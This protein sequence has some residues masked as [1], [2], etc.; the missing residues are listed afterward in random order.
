MEEALLYKRVRDL[1]EKKL[2]DDMIISKL[3]NS[4]YQRPE[5]YHAFIE[6]Y[7]DE[8]SDKD[9]ELIKNIEWRFSR[10]ENLHDIISSLTG[11][12]Y[13]Y[14]DIQKAAL[15]ADIKEGESASKFMGRWSTYTYMNALIFLAVIIL[16]ISYNKLFFIA[17][18]VIIVAWMS[19]TLMNMEGS[20][21]LESVM[22]YDPRFGR[23]ISQ[24]ASGNG[25]SASGYMKVWFFDPDIGLAVFFLV[26]SIFS[27]VHGRHFLIVNALLASAALMAAVFRPIDE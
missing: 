11:K 20:R 12:G 25:T 24:S 18:A 8:Y 14:Y 7:K 17:A 21:T 13:S 23:A 1:K 5:I 6:Y 16:A 15:R 4:G 3:E 10:G 27:I 26:F 2:S 9:D 19:I 22:Q